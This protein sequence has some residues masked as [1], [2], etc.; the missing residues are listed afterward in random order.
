MKFN[1]IE[2]AVRS[3]F[4]V[5][6]AIVN[7]DNI[8]AEMFFS[9]VGMIAEIK[10]IRKADGGVFILFNLKPYEAVN[11]DSMTGGWEDVKEPLGSVNFEDY[12]SYIPNEEEHF[13]SLETLVDGHTFKFLTNLQANS[14]FKELESKSDV[15]TYLSY[16]SW[17]ESEIL[18]GRVVSSNLASE[19]ALNNKNPNEEENHYKDYLE[20]MARVE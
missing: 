20:D 10:N 2:D 7:T 5:R 18:N 15:E 3:L 6:V 11:I 19:G 12:H 1:E 13:F 9:D 14:L 16:Y 4:E 8:F 17:L